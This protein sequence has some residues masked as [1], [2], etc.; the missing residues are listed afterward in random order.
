VADVTLAREARSSFWIPRAL[1]DKLLE[2]QTTY[3]DRAVMEKI[4][5]NHHRNRCRLLRIKVRQLEL[6]IVRIKAVGGES[7]DA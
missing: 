1:V 3:G 5:A 7:G 6:D 4:R 2:T